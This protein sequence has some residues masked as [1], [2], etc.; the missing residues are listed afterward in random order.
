MVNVRKVKVAIH[1]VAH[2]VTVRDSLVPASGAMH[3]TFFMAG[4]GVVRRA[5]RRIGRAHFDHVL[6]DVP[7]VHMVKMTVMDVVHVIIV[8]HGGVAASGAMH[9]RVV[10]MLGVGALAHGCPPGIAA[11]SDS[12]GVHEP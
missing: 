11:A 1:D 3:V 10:C 9:M 5:S 8:A 12:A 6:V 2:V 4:T 7:V